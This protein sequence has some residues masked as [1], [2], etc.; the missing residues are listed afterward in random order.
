MLARSKS[1]PDTKSRK[2]QAGNTKVTLNVG[3][4][5]FQTNYNTLV[6]SDVKPNYFA[7]ALGKQ[8]P[9]YTLFIDRDADSFKWILN[10]LR[11]Y[12][13]PE[14]E[15][16]LQKHMLLVDARFYQLDDLVQELEKQKE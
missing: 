2:Q 1:V 5:L 7:K 14:F 3:G 10:F 16:K 12:P 15:N 11:G 8:N 4:T 6:P 9:P 13:L